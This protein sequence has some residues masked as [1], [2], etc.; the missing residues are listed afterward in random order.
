MIL[1][2]GSNIA[3][4]KI[5]LEKCRPHKDFGRGFYLTDIRR[6]AERMA[7]R[8]AKMF[9]GEPTLTKFEF[10]L[11]AAGE[12]GLKIKIFDSPNHEWARFVMANRSIG[13]TQPVHDYDIV[14]GPVADDTI[15]RLL[16]MFSENFIDEQQLLKE[17]TFSEVT[18]QYCF[19]TRAAVEMLR[20][21]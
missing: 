2:H 7:A 17:L 11:D 6:Q 21:I 8:T 19:H 9:K 16:R 3:I 13:T 20:K 10:D 5:D 15:A 4:E 1:Y 12:A 18:S 14:I